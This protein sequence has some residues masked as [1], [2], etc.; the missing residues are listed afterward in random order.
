M[1]HFKDPERLAPGRYRIQSMSGDMS[2]E[3]PFGK[4]LELKESQHVFDVEK[5]QRKLEHNIN[6]K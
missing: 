5:G 6:F 3:N 1:R 4:L 2:H